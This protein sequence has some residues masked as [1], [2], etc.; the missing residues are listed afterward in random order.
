MARSGSAA[1]WSMRMTPGSRD[2][3]TV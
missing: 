2:S 3:S 1:S